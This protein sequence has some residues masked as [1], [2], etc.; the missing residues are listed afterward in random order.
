MSSSLFAPTDKHDHSGSHI[1]ASFILS[2]EAGVSNDGS[3]RANQ[4]R[5]RSRA[6]SRQFSAAVETLSRRNDSRLLRFIFQC[7]NICDAFN[8]ALFVLCTSV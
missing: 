2:R 4:H 3:F 1:E 7:F 6:R 8:D 5:S